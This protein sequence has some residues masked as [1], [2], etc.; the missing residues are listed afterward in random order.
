M[1]RESRAMRNC[2]ENVSSDIL[3][4]LIVKKLSVGL[5]GERQRR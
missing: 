4:C 1:G 2:C 5:S 3:G